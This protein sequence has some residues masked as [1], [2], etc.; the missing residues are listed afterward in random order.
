MDFAELIRSRTKKTLIAG[1]PFASTSF[2]HILEHGLVDLIVIGEGEVTIID[3]IRSINK[4]NAIP[5]NIPGTAVKINGKVIKNVKRNFI[6]NPDEI[7]FPDYD[8]IN[9]DDYSGFR[10]HAFQETHKSAYIFCTRG[11]PY[12]CVYCHQF[13]GKKMRRRSAK[14]I[15]AEMR[16]IN[17]RYGLKSFVVLD[18]CFNVPL[19]R[20]KE[21]LKL[22]AK[23]LPDVRINFPNG[24]RADKID[25]E[26]I[27]LLEMCNCVEIAL[28]VETA[29]PRLQKYIGK[30]L[31]LEKAKL[32][33]DK[34]SKKFITTV[35]FMVG[36]PTETY[37]EALMT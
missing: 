2:N 13:F 30:K 14:N 4:S 22:I 1:G 9:I 35:F 8:L 15:I 25:D 36:F 37:D 26:F 10:N 6:E 7:A 33:I 16:E 24:L 12:N 20:G 21:V 31:N 5:E 18:D 34:I 19:S 28:A 29:S 23:E 3:V 32:N 11:C 17:T 27:D